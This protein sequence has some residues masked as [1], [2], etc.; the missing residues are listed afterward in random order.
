LL[1]VL[2]PA[3]NHTFRDHYLEVDLDL[4]DVLFIPTANVVDTI[5]G[6]LL[7]RM[8]IVQLDGYTLQEKLLIARD[9]LVGRQL[10]R[11]GLDAADVTFSEDALVGIVVRTRRSHGRMDAAWTRNWC[12]RAIRRSRSM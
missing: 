6:P 11:N 3:Q 10:E 5:P 4:S 9:H 8:E 7:D 1:E 2:D 12:P